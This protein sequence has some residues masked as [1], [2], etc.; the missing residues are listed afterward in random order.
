MNKPFA[1]LFAAVVCVAPAFAL[2]GWIHDDMGLAKKLAAEQNKGILIEFTGSDWC[3]PC[4]A[5][6]AN[7]MTKED[8]ITEASKS[9]ILLELDYPRKKTQ[10]NGV[11]MANRAHAGQYGV[12][13]YPTVVFADKDGRPFGSFV[14]GMPK[15]KVLAAMNDALKQKELIAAAEAQAAA[16]TT[17]EAKITALLNLLKLIPDNYADSFYKEVKE[18]VKKLDPQDKTGIRAAEERAARYRKEMDE[19]RH[20]LKT[21]VYPRS[22]TPESSLKMLKAY[23]PDRAKLLPELRQ[24]LLMAEFSAALHATGDMDGLI[25]MLEEAVKLGADTEQGKRAAK[26]KAMMLSNKDMIVKRILEEKKKREE[27]D[28]KN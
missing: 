4:Q 16:A 9:F 7:V 22:C 6:R 3:P 26:M 5:L 10:D 11:K 19:F 28:K 18:T 23:Y 2:G 14:G 21:M 12:R 27:T 25:P 15:D 1:S 20:Y 13:G 17:D 24:E 8:F